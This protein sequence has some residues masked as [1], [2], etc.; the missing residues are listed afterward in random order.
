MLQLITIIKKIIAT[1]KHW[2]F[3]FH[4]TPCHLNLCPFW[5]HFQW[6]CPTDAYVGPKYQQETFSLSHKVPQKYFLITSPAN[7][8]NPFIFKKPFIHAAYLPDS[9]VLFRITWHTWHRHALATCSIHSTAPF[10]TPF[11]HL[12]KPL[13]WGTYSVENGRLLHTI[14]HRRVWIEWKKPAKEFCC[15]CDSA[16]WLWWHDNPLWY[17][18]RRLLGDYWSWGHLVSSC[19][20]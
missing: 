11:T 6:I 14:Q 10:G 1:A 12:W 19:N 15:C 8:T 18:Y 5:C 13:S 4:Y 20:A 7:L 3:C 16:V 9:S 2:L 17:R